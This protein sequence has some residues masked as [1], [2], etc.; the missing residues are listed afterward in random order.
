M[1]KESASPQDIV[2]YGQAA[3]FIDSSN[4]V[5]DWLPGVVGFMFAAMIVV[6]G[7]AFQSFIVPFRTAITVSISLAFIFGAATLVYVLG[8]IQGAPQL[9][10]SGAICEFVCNFDAMHVLNYEY[11]AW[12]AFESLITLSNIPNPTMSVP[13][14]T[15]QSATERL[16]RASTVHRRPPRRLSRLRHLRHLSA[17]RDATFQR[18][19][20]RV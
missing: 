8:D 9:A 20:G 5:Y 17:A 10:P 13:A 19:R 1:L 16:D 7:V 12:C 4:I 11:V 18:G 14:R 6:M 2:L 3:A 15:T